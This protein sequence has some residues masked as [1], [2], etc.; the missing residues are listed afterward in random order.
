MSVRPADIAGVVE[1]I[2]A[3][4]GASLKPGAIYGVTNATEPSSLFCPR[5]KL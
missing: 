1:R 3:V 4:N 5:I 2:A